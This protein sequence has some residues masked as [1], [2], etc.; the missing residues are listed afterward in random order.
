MGLAETSWF[1]WNRVLI[2]VLVAGWEQPWCQQRAEL[3][4]S[5]KPKVSGENCVVP[6]ELQ[7]I[8]GLTSTH[9]SA[10][11]SHNGNFSQ[12]SSSL[13]L[14]TVCNSLEYLHRCLSWEV[15]TN[16]TLLCLWLPKSRF[17]TSLTGSSHLAALQSA[18]FLTLWTLTF[19]SALVSVTPLQFWSL[20]QPPVKILCGTFWSRLHLWWGI[21]AESSRTEMVLCSFSKEMLASLASEIKLYAMDNFKS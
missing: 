18:A 7:Y 2:I 15:V 5:F 21:W 13:T 3:T 4:Q 19:S 20:L 12:V 16:P 9:A 11:T 6:W 14:E 8:A 1:I 17:L 10:W